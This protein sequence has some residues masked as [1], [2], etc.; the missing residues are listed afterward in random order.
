VGIVETGYDGSSSTINYARLR[1]PQ[2]QNFFILAHSGYLSGRNGDGLGKRGYPVR[3]DLSVVQNELS[4]HGNFP[5]RFSKWIER[6]E[7]A[8]PFGL[9]L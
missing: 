2:A 1:T 5:F 9:Y 7:E 6:A 4:R 3:G 8:P